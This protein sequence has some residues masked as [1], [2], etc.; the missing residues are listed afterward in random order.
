M[1]GCCNE[2]R[3]NGLRAPLAGLSYHGVAGIITDPV[4][5]PPPAPAPT[6]ILTAEDVQA[7]GQSAS[8][9]P[10]GV[11]LPPGMEASAPVVA[12]VPTAK[13]SG[14]VLLALLALGGVGYLMYGR[15]GV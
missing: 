14:G 3:R 1:A 11:V 13:A 15:K 12:V 6:L 5:I 9:P 7:A 10:P 2:V 4:N 8:A